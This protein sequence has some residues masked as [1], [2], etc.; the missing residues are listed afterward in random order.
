[1]D[2][3]FII[4]NVKLTLEDSKM[5]TLIKT[6]A[7]TLAAS[8]AFLACDNAGINLNSAANDP[9]NISSCRTYTD[10]GGPIEVVIVRDV[11]NWMDE[12]IASGGKEQKYMWIAISDLPLFRNPIEEPEVSGTYDAATG[13]TTFIVN[14]QE[15]TM[16]EH[17]IFI[18]AWAEEATRLR[19]EIIS[20]Y[21]ASV[22]VPGEEVEVRHSG[23]KALMT[24]EDVAEVAENNEGLSVS[25]WQE[26]IDIPAIPGYDGDVN[27][28]VVN[29]SRCH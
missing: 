8:I 25:F 6:F 28:E 13:E 20:S 4:R 5:K 29:T 2:Y 15:M 16:D 12:Q 1:L 9:F 27:D 17:K 23:W 3:T 10:Y 21:M 7:C 26:V 24:A 11:K 19:E 14:G 22:H 18:N